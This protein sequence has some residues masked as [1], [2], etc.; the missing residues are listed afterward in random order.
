MD[1]RRL[2]P[3]LVLSFSLFMLWDAWLKQGQ[4]KPAP[5]T[6]AVPA[7]PGNAA[8]PTPASAAVPSV[9]AVPGVPG[10]PGVPVAAPAGQASAR[11]TIRTD[12]VQ[13]DV[14]AQGGDIVHLE[15][16]KH[17]GTEDKARNFVLLDE[18]HLY[19]AQNG[20]IGAGLPSHKSVWQFD[21]GSRELKDG[22][23][24]L[25]LRMTA[26][27]EGGV[28]V[29]KTYVFRR[30]DYLIDVEYE[31]ANGGTTALAPHAYFQL[32]RDGKP[33]EG[34]TMMVSTFTGPAVY[35]DA[36]KFQKVEFAD[37]GK[38]KYVTKSSD[39]WVAMVQHY[40]VSA[41]LPKAG[42]EREFYTRK[43]GE[44]FFAAG[45]IVPMA[46]VAP[47]AR[48]KLAVP[49]YAGPQEQDKLKQIAPGLDLVVDYGWL[50][51]I[52]AP[53]FWV[54]EWIHKFTGDR[55]SVV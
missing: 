30:G 12:L 51:V 39:G 23:N 13:A 49:L 46:A 25:R 44:D 29:A 14:S 1:T 16:L 8:V 41:W 11:V 43:L 54:L 33:P 26:V 24:E 28:Q 35:S 18:R 15:F 55:K 36:G 5:A 20:L 32:V 4:P 34:G 48:G 3:L 37:V 38:A 53:L 10:V 17:R 27:A 42:D 6:A 47:G 50:T 52:A 2:I 22:E 40:F 45:V 21:G 7:A 31:I 9:A 19:A